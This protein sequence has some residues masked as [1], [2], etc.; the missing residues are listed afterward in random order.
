GRRRPAGSPG[1][2]GQGWVWPVWLASAD[3]RSGRQTFASTLPAAHR[4]PPLAVGK[5]RMTPGL[6]SRQTGARPASCRTTPVQSPPPCGGSAR[7][8]AWPVLGDAVPPSE[9]P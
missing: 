5:T 1:G 3:H 6:V 8:E 2:G 4:T 9:S 7:L